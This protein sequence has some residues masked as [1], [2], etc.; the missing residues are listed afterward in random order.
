MRDTRWGFY[1]PKATTSCVM[2]IDMT[3]SLSVSVQRLR[4]H[5]CKEQKFAK[6]CRILQS[7]KVCTPTL[8]LH[9][10]QLVEKH[11]SQ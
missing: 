5:Q 9:V 6:L 7:A 8:F 11:Y 1:L 3:G 4:L 2:F 10:L